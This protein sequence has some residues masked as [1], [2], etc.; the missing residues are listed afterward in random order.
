MKSIRTR[1]LEWLLGGVALL[2]LIA[3]GCIYLTAR[4]VLTAGV[5]SE[6]QQAR[7]VVFNLYQ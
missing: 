6:L 7:K 4:Y 5:E 1:L 2:F 3:G